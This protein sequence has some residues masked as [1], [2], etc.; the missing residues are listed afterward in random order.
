MAEWRETSARGAS[1]TCVWCG[2]SL[3]KAMSMVDDEETKRRC[4][5][6]HT[7]DYRLW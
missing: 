7:S 4:R 5:M 3:G 1:R 2:H 6:E